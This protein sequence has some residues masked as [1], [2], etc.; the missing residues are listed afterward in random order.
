MS[1]IQSSG[2]RTL[3]KEINSLLA[4]G[5]I[6]KVSGA[7]LWLHL[8]IIIVAKKN[9]SDIRMCVDLKKLNM[10]VRR[11]T[12]PQLTPWEVVRNI[13]KGTKH[14]AVFDAFK[15]YHQIVLDEES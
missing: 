9:T 8:P 1:Q 4:Q 15:G 14:Y 7:T 6:E 2:L 12:N 10:F 11:P 3:R 5:I 13:P